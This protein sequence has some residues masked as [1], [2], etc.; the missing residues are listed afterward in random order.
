MLL[1]YCGEVDFLDIIKN[2]YEALRN[3]GKRLV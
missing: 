1:R 3:F 2:T